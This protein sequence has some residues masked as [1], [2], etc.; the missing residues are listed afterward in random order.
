MFRT[1]CHKNAFTLLEL[2]VT[3]A[4]VVL[5][6]VLL[7]PVLKMSKKTSRRVQCMSNLSQMTSAFEN[8]CVNSQGTS[9]QF[10]RDTDLSWM[11][12]LKDSGLSP[13]IRFCPDAYQALPLAGKDEKN[14]GSFQ[15]AWIIK[16]TSRT[17]AGPS[18][19]GK[20]AKAG[21][22]DIDFF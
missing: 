6:V 13:E 15:W 1:H 19:D 12:I 10:D 22:P 14:F 2:A 21:D 11:Y 9:L 4:I 5:L 7:L 16:S 18:A 20:V 8:Y 3:F 17:V